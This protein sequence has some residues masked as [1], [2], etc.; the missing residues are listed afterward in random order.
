MVETLLFGRWRIEISPLAAK[1][2]CYGEPPNGVQGA[3][4]SIHYVFDRPPKLQAEQSKNRQMLSPM[5]AQVLGGHLNRSMGR[6]PHQMGPPHARS[7]LP[8]RMHCV[9]WG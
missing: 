3:V 8:H 7:R 5:P 6:T 2:S 1:P 9:D 4:I